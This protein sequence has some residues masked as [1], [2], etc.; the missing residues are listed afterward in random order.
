MFPSLVIAV[1]WCC[2]LVIYRLWL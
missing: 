2:R 1:L